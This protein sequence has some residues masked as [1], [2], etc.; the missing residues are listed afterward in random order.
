[1]DENL[2]K[3]TT[4]IEQHHVLSLATF[5]GTELSVCSMFYAYS[6]EH[7]CFVVASS[8]ET[9]HIQNIQLHNQ[10]AANILLETKEVG[11]I[12]GLQ[13]KGNF[14]PLEERELKHLYFKKF[15]YALAMNPQLWKI[16]VEHFKFTDNRL[17]FGKKLIW[18]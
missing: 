17:G 2:Q 13:I 16:E 18:P 8:H 1:M 3:I 6:K 11:K 9:Q 10:I 12:Q 7:N 14:L 4:F 5:S 15:P